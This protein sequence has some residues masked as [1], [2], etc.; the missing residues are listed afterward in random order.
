M[1]LLKLRTKVFFE[2]KTCRLRYT[3]RS[4]RFYKNEK[5][6]KVDE[7]LATV[8]LAPKTFTR[9]DVVEISTHGGSTASRAVLDTIIK[10]RRVYGRAR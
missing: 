8:M 7:V 5:G 10:S 6:E 4:L 1:T 3:Y 9:E 2:V